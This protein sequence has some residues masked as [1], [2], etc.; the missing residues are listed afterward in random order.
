MPDIRVLLV[1]DRPFVRTGLRSVLAGYPD[2][3]IV[4]EAASLDRTLNLG[5]ESR[6]S[7]IVVNRQL[8]DAD[9]AGGISSLRRLSPRPQ[10]LVLTSCLDDDAH[11]AVHA[12]ATGLLFEQSNHHVIVSALRMAAAGYLMLAQQGPPGN[13]APHGPQPRAVRHP[14][15]QV[16]QRELD[17]LEHIAQGRSNAEI[18]AMLTLS[19]N[20]VKTHVCSL[21]VKLGL[22]N[23][24]ALV[25]YAYEVGLV[26]SPEPATPDRLRD[27]R[28][29]TQ[30]TGGT[31]SA[32][33]RKRSTR[34]GLAS[35]AGRQAPPPAR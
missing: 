14:L 8:I 7:V 15:D 27:R 12:G 29:R 13:G 24:V 20:T 21:L 34:S 5:A 28:W 4:G 33:E 1:D 23:R 3:E 32:G 22:R 17:V 6:P 2:I 35:A 19:P 26:P 16:T 9:L 30:S 11:R 10:V 31:A 25:I 18:S